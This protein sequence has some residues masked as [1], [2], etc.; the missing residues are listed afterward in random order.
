LGRRRKKRLMQSTRFQEV[1]FSLML[2]RGKTGW[3]V[4]GFFL[5]ASVKAWYL[6]G[7]PMESDAFLLVFAAISFFIVMVAAF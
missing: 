4:T 6:L 5:F 3:L 2:L 7:K 1:R